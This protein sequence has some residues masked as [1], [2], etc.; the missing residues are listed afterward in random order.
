MSGPFG[1]GPLLGQFVAARA[2]AG[3]NEPVPDELVGLGKRTHDQG[4]SGCEVGADCE[5]PR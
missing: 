2:F 5:V 4:G 1:F 3:N